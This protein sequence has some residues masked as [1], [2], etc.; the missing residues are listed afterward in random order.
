MKVM[1]AFL[2]LLLVTVTFGVARQQHG[3][4]SCGFAVQSEPTL[5]QLQVQMTSC[6]WSTWS[7]NLIPRLRSFLW[8]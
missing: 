1:F 7:N 3:T 2:G 4:E 8:T 6:L 5:R